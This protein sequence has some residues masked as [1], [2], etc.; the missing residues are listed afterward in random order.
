MFTTLGPP[1]TQPTN[2]ATPW[3]ITRDEVRAILN[4]T[5]K[6]LQITHRSVHR[7]TRRALFPRVI[8]V[9]ST[10]PE[11]TDT[12]PRSSKAQ[13]TAKKPASNNG[14]GKKAPLS[15][16]TK[17]LR[18]AE[19]EESGKK[20]RDE[21]GTR[22]HPVNP[23]GYNCPICLDPKKFS[24]QGIRIHLSHCLGMDHA[25][26]GKVATRLQTCIRI[27]QVQKPKTPPKTAGAKNL[28]QLKAMAAKAKAAAVAVK[29][30]PPQVKRKSPSK[31]PALKPKP[32]QVQASKRPPVRKRPP[33]LI[34]IPRYPE[35]EEST[36][37]SAE[38]EMGT[39]PQPK[40]KK[41]TKRPPARKGGST[42]T[43]GL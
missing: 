16:T 4:P 42:E 7:A 18:V 43:Q 29:A 14:N 15:P 5:A 30:T 38:S 12:T 37:S 31:P 2:G 28:A 1:S 8:P 20:A 6:L 13:I 23:E 41:V 34:P 3:D 33:K 25:D 35:L 22:P 21:A 39:Q 10:T 36:S 19:L 27:L 9:R 11:P 24:Y 40:K 26:L 17:A 32:K